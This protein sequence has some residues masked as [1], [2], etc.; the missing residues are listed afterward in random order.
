M[1]CCLSHITKYYTL[2]GNNEKISILKDISLSVD[3][4]ES[5]AIVGPSGSGK[6]TL[7]NILATLDRKYDGSVMIDAQDI[8]KVT[9]NELASIRNRKVG[10]VFQQHFLLPYLTLWENILVPT[11]V[12][13]KD[14]T[15]DSIQDRARSLLEKTGLIDRMGHRPDQLSGGECQR[16][17]VVRALINRPSVLCADEPTGSLDRTTAQAL[18]K[19]L[20]TLNRDENIALVVVT[21][22]PELAATLDRRYTLRDGTLIEKKPESL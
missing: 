3:K 2:P 7:L 11:L 18:G 19:L 17:A 10:I 5:V 16:A 6:T 20:K 21:H 9:D 4:G 14:R 15:N 13:Q 8:S 1:I 22:S 12:W